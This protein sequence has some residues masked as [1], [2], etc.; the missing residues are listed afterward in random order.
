MYLQEALAKLRAIQDKT[1]NGN[2]VKE[3][4]VANKKLIGRL[5]H[6][7]QMSKIKLSVSRNENTTLKK[8]VEE[9][10]RDKLLHLQIYNSLVSC[11]GAKKIHPCLF[12]LPL[13]LSSD[14]TKV[15]EANDAKRKLK[16]QQKE[17]ASCNERK[18]KAK[19]A[20]ATIK[21][22][23]LK[24]MEEFSHELNLA[25]QNI[26]NAQT[27][28][29]AAMREKMATVQLSPS[30][31]NNTEAMSRTVAAMQE[32]ELAQTRL[33]LANQTDIYALYQEA[34]V[35]SSDELITKLETSEEQMFAL[36]R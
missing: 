7:L 11:R 16:H 35:T 25:K 20:V 3:H 1:K 33:E 32:A 2:I 12:V 34:G 23:M 24:D 28:I 14:V 8:K 36:Y 4:D 22:K 19:V 15:K 21:N 13:H 31:F 29:I 18:H 9:Q 30:R 5:E 10:R 17:I 6:H 26:S 27:S